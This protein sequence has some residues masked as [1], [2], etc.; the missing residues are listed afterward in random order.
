[1][2]RNRSGQS[3]L[4]IV[5]MAVALLAADGWFSTA[6]SADLIEFKVGLSE[7][8]NTALALWM[9]E[10]G[11]FYAAR[12]LKVEIINMNGGSRGAQEL[13]AG[14]LDAMHVGLSSV[15]RINRSGGDL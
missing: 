10:A 9:A 2:G 12:G 4:R 1:M 11:G 13:Q 15:V 7:P 6:K 5:S 3:V 14:R 8:V